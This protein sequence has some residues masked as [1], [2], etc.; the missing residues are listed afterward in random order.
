MC[1]SLG[2]DGISIGYF[3][4]LSQRIDYRETFY[5]RAS[6]SPRLALPWK[7]S[8]A[9]AGFFL[10]SLFYEIVKFTSRATNFPSHDAKVRSGA[11]RSFPGE[12]RFSSGAFETVY[13][14]SF[15]LDSSSERQSLLRLNLAA[16]DRKASLLVRN[17]NRRTP[18]R[19]RSSAKDARDTTRV[20]VMPF[21]EQ[22]RGV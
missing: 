13:S 22:K 4:Q 21:E 6:T 20:L 5:T 2:G 9:C 11:T 14:D 19:K 16:F 12:E 1:F 10:S 7:N 8:P 18:G 3:G 17:E 15:A